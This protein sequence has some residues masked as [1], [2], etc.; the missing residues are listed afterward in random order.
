[1]AKRKKTITDV[2]D[3]THEQGWS[4]SSFGFCKCDQGQ[5]YI[6]FFAFTSAGLRRA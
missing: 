4:C 1:V 5:S 3:I 2:R 6:L